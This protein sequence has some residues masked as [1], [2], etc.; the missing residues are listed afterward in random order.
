MRPVSSIP[1]YVE[2][3]EKLA[4][5]FTEY[6]DAFAVANPLVGKPPS[7]VTMSNQYTVASESSSNR[8]Y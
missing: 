1:P 5:P 8:K 3:L 2:S 4:P 7:L 6:R